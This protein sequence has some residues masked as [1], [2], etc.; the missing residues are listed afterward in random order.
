MC[1]C[2]CVSVLRHDHFNCFLI[3]AE[4]TLNTYCLTNNASL[5]FF[6]VVP[7]SY[8]YMYM[9]SGMQKFGNPL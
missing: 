1:V 4:S 7:K 2:V 6:P 5:F 3:L 8:M 9:Y